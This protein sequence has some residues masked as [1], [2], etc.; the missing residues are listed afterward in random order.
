MSGDVIVTIPLNAA[1]HVAYT[2][3]DP[4]GD[5]LPELRDRHGVRRPTQL[6]RQVPGIDNGVVEVS[7]RFGMLA[8]FAN[9]QPAGTVAAFAANGEAAEEGR[10]VAIARI[11]DRLNPVGVKEQAARHDDTVARENRGEARRQV[12]GV[13]LREPAHRRLVQLAA[14]LDKVGLTASA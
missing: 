12:L 3:G 6:G 4:G 2:T 11:R 5:P 8:P 7:G 1:L 9:V 13:G 10:F 14:L